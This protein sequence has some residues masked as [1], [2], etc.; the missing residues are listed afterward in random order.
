VSKTF[1][2]SVQ[3][4]R[5][6]NLIEAE[7]SASKVS[8]VG[9][10]KIATEK[11]GFEVNNRHVQSRR[12]ELGIPLN[13]PPSPDETRLD[14]IERDGAALTE[15]V[16]EL[17]RKLDIVIKVLNLKMHFEGSRDGHAALHPR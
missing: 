12:V 8:D 9:F 15:V 14:R 4:A 10:A 1:L 11:L 17:T 7:Y 13:G 16:A 6:V 5:L 2:T 3:S